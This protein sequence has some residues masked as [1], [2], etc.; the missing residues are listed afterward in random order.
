MIT[1]LVGQKSVTWNYLN[2]KLRINDSMTL[3]K[4]NQA[5]YT[6]ETKGVATIE[7]C[8]LAQTENYI[9]FTDCLTCEH[10]QGTDGNRVRCAFDG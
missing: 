6:H 5:R 3:R 9:Y 2:P 8:P 7:K 1:A 4:I 10:H